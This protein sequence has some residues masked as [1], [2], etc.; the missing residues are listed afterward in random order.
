MAQW[1]LATMPNNL[2][3]IPVTHMKEGENKI[4][5]VAL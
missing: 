4:P 2:S 3:L 1:V 5:Q